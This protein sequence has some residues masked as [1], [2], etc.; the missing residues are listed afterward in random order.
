MNAKQRNGMVKSILL[1]FKRLVS[2]GEKNDRGPS[3]LRRNSS[4]R[5]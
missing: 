1:N 2:G 5:N 4:V 3:E